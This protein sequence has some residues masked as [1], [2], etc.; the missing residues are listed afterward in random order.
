MISKFI[1]AHAHLNTTSIE[2]MELAVKRNA[3]FLSI[4]TNI[5]FFE[6]I[7]DQEKVILELQE[8]YPGRIQYITSFNFE[9][10]GKDNFAQDAITQ[11][12]KGLSNG[13]VGVKIWK[14]VG[15]E[16][17]D[18]EGN[19]VMIDNPVFDPIFQFLVDNDILLIGHQGE[20]RNCWLPL[21]EMTVDSD[22]NYFLEHPEYHMFLQKEYPTYEQ[23]MQARD[24]MLEKFPTLRYVGLHLFSME[25][26]IEE[27]AKRLER[28]PN[29]LTDL[30]ERVVHLQLQAK[31][32]REAVREFCIKYQDKI[33]YGTDVIDDGSLSGI[34]V[35]DRFEHLWDF[36]YAFFSTGQK[37][38]APEFEGEFFGLDL[39]DEVIEKI[40]YYNAKK[41]YNFSI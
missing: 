27:V 20:P 36:H 32:N 16:L 41:T 17:H 4:N 10:W 19:F 26:S 22:R 14:D 6:S 15:F 23:Q 18:E 25:Y 31:N 12:K 37:M 24:H 30:A 33:I 21:E 13:A 35:A 28:Y 40:F 38:K 9:N 2:K 3:A 11:I 8:K 7:E 39:P 1:D 34:E 29:T 5:P